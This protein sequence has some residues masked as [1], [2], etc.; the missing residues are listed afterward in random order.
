[1]S[2][3]GHV[4]RAQ[5]GINTYSFTQTL[6]AR[7]C[8]KRLADLGYCR[9]EIMLMPGH[10][11]AS[12]DGDAGRRQIESLVVKDSLQ[13]LTLNQPNLDVNLSSV[14]PEMREH[15]C[16]VISSAIELAA[17]WNAKGV[18]INPGK[19]NPV[20][21]P[22]VKTL[23]DCFRRSLE[24]LVPIARR[25]R[26]QLIVKNHPLSYLYRADDL[27]HFFDEFGWEQIG[28]G[29]DFANGHFAREEPEAVLQLR[30]HLSFMYAA[31]TSLD[32]FNHAQIGTGTVP[33]ERI[34][35]MLRGANLCPPTILEIVAENA[36][37]AIDASVEHLDSH[38]WPTS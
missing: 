1:M 34:A 22:P 23:A 27:R 37:L 13:I 9:F 36:Q 33:F 5:Y 24:V 19:S 3:T 10:F 21:P 17:S 32:V 25:A 26:V 2:I 31:D 14:V 6:A 35:T 11:W 38:R 4:T 15:S 8:L 30:Q 29:Y 28:I 18:V 16:G 20:F 7:D 12:L